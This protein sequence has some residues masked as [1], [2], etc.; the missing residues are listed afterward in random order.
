MRSVLLVDDDQ[1]IR[2]IGR[3]ALQVVGGLQVW[4][5]GSG[6]EALEAAAVHRPDVVLLDVM[7]PELSG[8]ETLVKLRSRSQ[9]C[10]IPVVFLTASV[11]APEVERYRA[12][13]AVGVIAK[14]FDPMTLAQALRQMV[15]AP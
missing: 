4:V 9:T 15:E 5:A 2:E 11:Q 3:L 8:P 10:D 7:M 14:P 13:G 12:M 6:N 1:D